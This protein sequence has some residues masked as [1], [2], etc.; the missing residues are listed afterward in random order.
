MLL[1]RS[2]RLFW[3]RFS[4]DYD[5]SGLCFRIFRNLYFLFQKFRVPRYAASFSCRGHHFGLE[6][7]NPNGF[8]DLSEYGSS[9]Y[10]PEF[11]AE[12]SGK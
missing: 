10:L 2:D 4:C 7:G 5:F 12:P 8:K 11:N 1:K 3:H 9:D 6:K